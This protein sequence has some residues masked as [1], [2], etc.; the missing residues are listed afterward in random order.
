MILASHGLIASQIASA[1]PDWAAFYGRVLAAG[2]SLS[3]TEQ[4]AT[5]T[6]VADLKAAGLWSS[7]K[8][9]YPM[10]GASAAACK[11]NLKSASFTG[12]FSSGWTFASTGATPNGI[13]AFMDTGLV[14]NSVFSNMFITMGVYIRTSNTTNTCDMGVINTAVDGAIEI[15]SYFGTVPPVTLNGCGEFGNRANYTTT[16]SIGFR[17][18]ARSSTTSLKAY[19]L[20]ALQITNTTSDTTLIS[21]FL[22][23]IYIGARNFGNLVNSPSDRETA[24]NYIADSSFTQQNMTNLYT[25]VQAFQTT[26][27]RQV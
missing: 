13:S 22:N 25:A 11:Q 8:A 23:P 5:K 21:E 17:S 3:T 27:S 16:D 12:T 18:F 1:D 15:F 24:F 7:M 2:G 26:L 4:N 10:V 6:L 14:P 9:I 20:D 19:L